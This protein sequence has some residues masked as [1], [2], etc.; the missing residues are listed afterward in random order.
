MKKDE[1]IETITL[2]EEELDTY[3]NVEKKEKPILNK[4]KKCIVYKVG[5]TEIILVDENGCGYKTD[6][7]PKHKKLKKG[8]SFFI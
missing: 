1:N 4:G 7:G 3:T 6:I 5:E 8:D 2:S